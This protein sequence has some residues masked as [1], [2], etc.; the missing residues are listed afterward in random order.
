MAKVLYIKANPKIE[1]SKTLKIS[2]EF[3][4]EYRKE[5]PSDEIKEID[6]YKENIDFLSLDDINSL[7]GEKSD[8]K[9]TK[10]VLKYAYEFKEADKMIFS[11]PM[12]NLAFPAILKAYIDYITVS[13]IT[14]RYT[15]NGAE[16]L[17]RDKKAI[18]ITSRGSVFSKEP[19]KDFEMGERYMKVILAFLGI[20]N[21]KSIVAEGVDM[22]SIDTN[23][24]V[25][26]AIEKA[27]TLARNF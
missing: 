26:D 15:S 4:K 21:F 7:F 23:K 11:A 17:C 20:T 1:G 3:V 8:E 27:K 2:D 14:F 22:S 18:Y 19:M 16:G 12:W 10:G 9:K 13:G 5:N 25:E 6:L 24:A